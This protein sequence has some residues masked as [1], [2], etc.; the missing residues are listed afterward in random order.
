MPT[1]AGPLSAE[2]SYTKCDIR[3]SE[4]HSCTGSHADRACVPRYHRV[5]S[6]DIK[7]T[8]TKSGDSESNVN[9]R[10]H[11]FHDVII[12]NVYIYTRSRLISMLSLEKLGQSISFA[13]ASKMG[14][15]GKRL[16]ALDYANVPSLY[17]SIYL[18]TLILSAPHFDDLDIYFLHTA[19]DFS[20]D[21]RRC[22]IPYLNVKSK[23][24]APRAP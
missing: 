8:L 6:F 23:P 16:H 13:A 9:F 18:S 19:F 1:G 3:L 11:I 4:E 12:R 5:I 21:R 14:R 20:L 24:R 7:G 10:W 22:S 17:R 15:E 2:R